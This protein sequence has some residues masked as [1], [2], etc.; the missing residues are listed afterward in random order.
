[1]TEPVIPPG[2]PGGGGL[3]RNLNPRQRRLAIVGA[4][5]ALLGLLVLVMRRPAAAPPATADDTAEQLPADYGYPAG[6]DPMSSY[7]PSSEY[8]A[9]I[10]S[11][12][13]DS[14][15][16]WQ[17]ANEELTAA[18]VAL[19]GQ[20]SDSGQ[21][22]GSSGRGRHHAGQRAGNRRH[23]PRHGGPNDG[24]PKPPKPHGSHG[25][26]GK[27]GKASKT[28]AVGPPTSHKRRKKGPKK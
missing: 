3:L 6:V 4:I 21:P 8:L 20:L 15:G 9:S 12:I 1:M 13:T 27:A 22:A 28:P 25:G 2:R 18:I 11:S 7:D 5:G 26:G 17:V 14:L 16:D 24:R 23:K 10:G 19:P